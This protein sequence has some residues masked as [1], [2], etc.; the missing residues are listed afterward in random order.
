MNSKIKNLSIN[1]IGKEAVI[2]GEI[3]Y[4]E[5]ISKKGSRYISAIINDGSDIIYANIFSRN[6]AL[7]DAVLG[8]KNKSRVRVVGKI[9]AVKSTDSKFN[10]IDVSKIEL[11]EAPVVKAAK[12]DV[13]RKE[14]ANIMKEIKNKAYKKLI[15]D[16]MKNVDNDAYYTVPVSDRHYVYQG[17]LVDHIIRTAKLASAIIDAYDGKLELNKEFMLTAILLFRVGK[18]KTLTFADGSTKLT[19]DGEFFEDSL[20]TLEIVKECLDKNNGISDY[21]KKLLLHMIAASKNKS[22]Y[23]ALTIP[24]TVSPFLLYH[25]EMISLWLENFEAAEEKRIDNENII[26]GPSGQVYILSAKADT[27]KAGDITNNTAKDT[28]A[29]T[30]NIENAQEPEINNDEIVDD[31]PIDE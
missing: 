7:Y 10:S 27:A 4:S 17:G 30:N 20:I 13:Q 6:T 11:I 12:K 26:Y 2:K 16:V 24:K 23:G 18:T 3:Q 25:I 5:K 19:E 29:D 15:V 28:D 1:D 8:I 31:I 9:E 14:L 21:E 22:I